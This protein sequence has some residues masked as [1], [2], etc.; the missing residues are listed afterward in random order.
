MRKIVFFLLWIST[1]LSVSAESFCDDCDKCFPR[2]AI[3]SNLLHDAVLTPDLGVEM[4]LARRFSVGVE[5][6]WAW[7][8]RHSAN[9]CWRIY[10]GWAHMDYWFGRQSNERALTGHHVG[11]YGSLLS[12]DFEFGNTGWQSPELTYGVGL[13]YG[14]SIE[15]APRLNLDFSIRVGYSGGDVVKYEPQCGQYVCLSHCF[16]RYFGPTDIGITLVWFP[17][18]GRRNNPDFGL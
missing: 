9:R 10:G 18:K 14:Y 8:S 1:I 13:S 6:V 3:K 17:G 12:Y 7:W 15:I 16:K 4:S 2:F 11:V 5:G